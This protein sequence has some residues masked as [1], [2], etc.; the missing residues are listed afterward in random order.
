[1]EESGFLFLQNLTQQRQKRVNVPYKAVIFANGLLYDGEILHQRLED[2]APDLTLAADGGYWPAHEVGFP[3][4]VVIG[5]LDSIGEKHDIDANNIDALVIDAPPAKDETDLELALQHAVEQG[6]EYIVI[7][8]ALG[9]R[10]DMAMA[11]LLLLLHPVVEGLIVEV[12]QDRQTI[13]VIKPPGGGCS[14]QIG[15]TLSLI[16]F[17]GNAEGITTHNLQYPLNNESLLIGP[18][19]GVSNVLSE[20]EAYID[21]KSGYL[22]AVHTSGRA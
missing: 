4:S 3:P 1:M 7:V 20:P 6:A 9:G 15:D 22:L 10:I 16:P 21:L 18:A 2:F 12:W 5:D 8:T 11:N 14:G 17:A 19:R 13:W